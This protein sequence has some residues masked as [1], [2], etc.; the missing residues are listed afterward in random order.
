M[1]LVAAIGVGLLMTG[2]GKRRKGAGGGEGPR[3][4]RGI[5]GGSTGEA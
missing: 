2:L 5:E 1:T 4:G 3:A